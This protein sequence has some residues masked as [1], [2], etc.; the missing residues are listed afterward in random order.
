MIIPNRQIGS[1]RLGEVGDSPVVTA[2]RRQ[3]Q[4]LFVDS[5]TLYAVAIIQ[6]SG[7]GEDKMQMHGWYSGAF[8]EETV[9]P[10]GK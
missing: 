10:T 2:G 8:W 4:D 5:L 6:D 7:G 1:L 3:S 9:M